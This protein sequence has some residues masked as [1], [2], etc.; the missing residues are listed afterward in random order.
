VIEHAN[1][2][3]ARQFA[4]KLAVLTEKGVEAVAREIF[5]V[6]RPAAPLASPPPLKARAGVRKSTRHSSRYQVE[7][8]KRHKQLRESIL[9]VNLRRMAKFYGFTKVSELV[10][11][12]RG[13]DEFPVASIAK[14]RDFF[15][16]SRDYLDEGSEYVFDSFDNVCSKHDCIKFLQNGFSP[17]IL[18]CPADRD[19]L[20]AYVV[21]QKEEQGFDRIIVSDADGYFAS[22]GGGKGNLTHLIEAMRDLKL[23]V[24]HHVPILKVAAKTWEALDNKTF[25]MP[26]MSG[27]RGPDDTA[28][29]VFDEW[30]LEVYAKKR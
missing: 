26:G 5:E 9:K 21:F 25:Y 10:A 18:T 14:L 17:Y 23:P 22:R 7:L 6:V 12:E 20:H 27:F 11:Y 30:R 13:E 16:V 8:G 1:T 15:F 3:F 29:R 2:H 28:R 24:A 4:D 19:Q